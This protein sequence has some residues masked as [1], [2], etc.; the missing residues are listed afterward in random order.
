M[1]RSGQ[2]QVN[3]SESLKKFIGKPIKLVYRDCKTS[4]IQR[5][6]FTD[7]DNYFVYI[8][9]KT[10]AIIPIENIIKISIQ[11]NV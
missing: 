11:E 7:I 9:G 1:A 5:G 10:K 6:I 3:L 4:S 8:E 2:E